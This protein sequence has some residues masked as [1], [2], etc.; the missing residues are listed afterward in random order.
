MNDIEFAQQALEHAKVQVIPGSL[1]QGGEGLIRI[2]YATSVD[3]IHEGIRRLRE[4]L[5]SR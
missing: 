4:W 3:N 5:E 2:S 1:M